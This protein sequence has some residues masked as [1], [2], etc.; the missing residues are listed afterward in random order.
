[1]LARRR[2]ILGIEKQAAQRADIYRYI[3][4]IGRDTMQ[5]QDAVNEIKQRIQCTQYLTKSKHGMYVCPWC[6]SGEGT[7]GTGALKYYVDKNVVHCHIC[8]RGADVINLYKQVNGEI[9]TAKA[10][11][12][13]AKS[14][15]IYIDAPKTKKAAA[16]D[17]AK[18]DAQE[19][20]KDNQNTDKTEYYRECR[21]RLTDKEASAYLNDRGIS[22]ETA[23]AYWI[24]Y[25][26]KADPAGAGHPCKR[27]IVPSS[28]THYM[29]RRIDGVKEWAK[30]N[31]KGATAGIFN[32]QA[33]YTGSTVFITEGAFDALSILEVGADA[34][35]LNGK[36]NAQHLIDRIETHGTRA[37]LILSLDNDPAGQEA[38][39]VL[40]DGLK[41]LNI[42][43][44][45][46][47]ICG[48]CK[49]PNEALTSNRIS[50][51]KAVYEAIDKATVPDSTSLYID[52]MM[53]AEIAR[54]KSEK[55]TGFNNLD[56]KTGGLYSGL[57][58]IGAISSL[59]KTTFALQMADQ[60]AADG[61]DVLF[62]S[63]EQSRLEMV[64]KSLA[65][66]QAQKNP[67]SLIT[68][69][70]I[71]KGMFADTVQEIAQEYK[72]VIGHRMNIIEGNMRCNLSFICEKVRNYVL[73]NNV[74]PVVFIDYLQILQGQEDARQSIREMV[75][76]TLTE[77]RRLSRE[78]DLTIFVISSLNR[79]N[80]LTPVDFESFKESGGIEYTCD[81]VY[82][83][84]LECMN[85][86][87]FDKQNN[88][89]EKRDRVKECKAEMPRRVE[90]CCL[91]NRYGAPSFSCMYKYYP[92]KDLFFE[93]KENPQKLSGYDW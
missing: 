49:D 61:N 87:V 36:G 39:K 63:L 11:E 92:D 85:E 3:H 34:I 30:V 21:A 16:A 72:E 2:A 43:F 37:T 73:R 91:K 79:S 5:L 50:F 44:F 75:D 74:R 71:R 18:K 58:C 6:R 12:E 7:N 1:M 31:V 28:P 56:I 23:A 60:L 57:Y 82:G 19:V 8:H 80:Y 53:N 88:I 86:E 65:R 59:G 17:K 26:P 62:F 77:L 52:T 93:V 78:L 33:I 83:L 51:S 81:V 15:G 67:K 14:I 64:S 47:D 35:A 76:N 46:A 70:A 9:N 22:I 27:I 29:G 41:R 38:T 68:S 90:L 55:K 89:K 32:E 4:L 24:G 54:F 42:P 25:D 84:Q 40:Q 48:G 13:M 66:M 69:L 10:I 45:T 20:Q